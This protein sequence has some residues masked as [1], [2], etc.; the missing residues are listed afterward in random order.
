MLADMCETK[1]I[2]CVS[3]LNKKFILP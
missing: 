1:S 3:S 2:G